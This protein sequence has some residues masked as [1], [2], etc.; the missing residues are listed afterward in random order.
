MK[1]NSDIDINSESE[2]ISLPNAIDLMYIKI[3]E[4]KEKEKEKE[5]E[6][7]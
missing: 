7:K 5:K 3:L 2:P 6:K 1:N 4:M